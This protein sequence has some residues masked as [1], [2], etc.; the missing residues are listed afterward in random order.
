[1]AEYNAKNI[2]NVIILAHSGAG[3]TSV[4]E[5]LLSE[6]EVI[7]KPGS[8]DGGNTVSDYNKDEI[9]KKI[10]INSALLNLA[11]N[12]VKINLIDTPGY[13]D[14]VGEIITGITAVECA[15]IIVNAVNGIE[16]GTNQAFKFTQKKNMPAIVFINKMDKENADFNKCVGALQNKFG[17]KCV[18]TG[19][20]IG[21]ED[22]FKGIAN[23]LTK[24]GMELLE[25]ADEKNAREESKILVEGVAES[26][27][28]LLEK[29]LDTGELSHDE[30][31][32]AFRKGVVE[33]NIIPIIA[34]SIV[35]HLGI[36]ELLN[37]MVNYLPSPLDV[38]PKK[39]ISMSDN[40]PVEVKADKSACF[41]A[42]IF[43][44]ISDPYVGQ[45][46]IFRIFSG[47][48]SANVTLYNV[49]KGAR[50]K[51]GQ[52]ST[53]EGKQLKPVDKLNA[54][55]IG[56]IAKLK[57]T[58]TADSLG[59]EKKPIKF[60]DINTPEPAMSFSIKPKTRSDE[61]KISDALHRLAAEDSTFKARRDQQTKE[62]I[63]SG[64]GDLHLNIMIN[65][66]KERYGV[67]V[68]IGT[69]KVAYRETITAKGS[70]QYKHKKQSGGAG[71]FAEVWMRVETLPRGSGFEFV[72]EVVGG[73]IPA[74]FIVSC[75]KGV[76]MA[77][78][79]GTLAGCPVVDIKAVVY[80]GKTHP[81]DSKD[82]AFQIAAR[83][84]FKDAVHKAKP[85]LLEPIMDVEVV[86][87]EE[88]MGSVTGSLNSRRG[89]V[90]G[91]EPGDGA[92]MVKARVP[93]EE[94]YKYI[95]ELKSLTAGRGLYTMKFSHYE[96][97]P[98]NIAQIIIQ[99]AK[100]AKDGE[101]EK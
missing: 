10:S 65:R 56:C 60:P 21:K 81:V 9:E 78:E 5:H 35:S 33:G 34:G 84:A 22:S 64:M 3:K 93:L 98:S 47:S 30:V 20:P 6:A 85:V 43:K 76:R 73:A 75:E 54:G 1:M 18:V 39:G 28:A 66:L 101:K 19:H 31:K 53:M 71:Q 45:M 77:L 57:D 94:M 63:V 99:K 83:N 87:P 15:V 12:S 27:D 23:L 14:F 72:S 16:V 8:V 82:I 37:A 62:L 79:S 24:E 90:L 61:D 44:T 7:P 59:E 96:Q 50:E 11:Y 95:N 36:K 32:S 92:Q 88:Y 55:D 91:M 29:Y 26:D 51:T 67:Q 97:V 74:P 86:V 42:Q 48:L 89:R 70:S 25:G 2:R 40:N 80:D 46:S 4:A 58:Q 69:P 49:T 13:A 41:S 52:L 100:Q 68:D 38:S 17:K